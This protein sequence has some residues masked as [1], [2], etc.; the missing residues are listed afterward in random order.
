MVLE[1]STDNGLDMY[2]PFDWNSCWTG[3]IFLT[4]KTFSKNLNLY[5]R[6]HLFVFNNLS[7]YLKSQLIPVLAISKTSTMERI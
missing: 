2:G 7:D 6:F 4:Q 1:F 3:S 5:I